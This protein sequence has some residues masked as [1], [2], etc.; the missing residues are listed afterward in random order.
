MDLSTLFAA[1][2]IV[3]VTHFVGAITGYGST[4]LALPLLLLLVSDLKT[5]VVALLILGT[6]QPYHISLYTYRHVDWRQ[7]KHVL[8]MMG[9][10]LPI[11]A[12]SMRYLPRTALMLMLGITLIAG[13]L[14]RIRPNTDKRAAPP[15][16]TVLDILLLMGGVIHGAF[17][18]GGATLAI[19]AQYVL[20]RKNT[21]RGTLCMIW[22]ILNTFML[23]AAVIGGYVTAPVIRLALFGLPFLLVG[24]WLGEHSARRI[25]QERFTQLLAALLVASG[26][27]TLVRL[28]W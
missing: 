5:C 10:A 24:N 26:V 7:L 12:L 13:G 27:I 2:I 11:G 25:S 16:R 18:C 28:V 19:Y 23:A 1:G 14:S 4:L 3:L 15:P 6:V 22:V 20:V 17:A 21:V 8:L 9:I